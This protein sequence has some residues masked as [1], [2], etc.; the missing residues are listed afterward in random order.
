MGSGRPLSRLPALALFV[1]S[2]KNYYSALTPV[3]NNQT[4]YTNEIVY[5]SNEFDKIKEEKREYH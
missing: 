3:I 5:T 4:D 2:I 1:Y